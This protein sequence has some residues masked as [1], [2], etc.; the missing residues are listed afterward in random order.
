MQ[1]K[2][3][4]DY[5]CSPLW[6]DGESKNLGNIR[7]EELGLSKQVCADLWSWAAVFDA[8]LNHD[9]PRISGFSSEIREREFHECGKELTKRVGTELGPKHRVRYWRD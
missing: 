1:I 4:A 6:W 5:E 7:P 8:T 9:D 3:M 2:I